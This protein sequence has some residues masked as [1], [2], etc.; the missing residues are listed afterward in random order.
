MFKSGSRKLFLSLLLVAVLSLPV[1]A[2]YKITQKNHMDGIMGQPPTDQVI[3][4]LYSNAGVRQD[5]NEQSSIL[6]H[7]NGDMIFLNHAE[8]NYS[9]IDFEQLKPMLDMAMGMMG[10]I[11]TDVSNT[12]KTQKIGKYPTTL[13]KVKMTSQMFNM[14]LDVY[15]TPEIKQGDIY[16]KFQ[17]KW[18]LMQGPM[19]D[20]VKKMNSM[21]GF[22]VKTVGSVSVMGQ[23]VNMINEVTE[24]DSKAIPAKMF[25]VPAGYTKTE[26]NLTDMQGLK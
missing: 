2:D 9:V 14:D 23:T 22:A 4:I 11:K 13:W 3:V 10:E 18:A 19:A 24:V 1:L 6:F 20:M 5:I 17:E 25:A 15:V 8:K 12:G 16:K 7:P 26:F 21:D